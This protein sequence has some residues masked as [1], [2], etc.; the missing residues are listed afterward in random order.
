[1]KRKV[2]VLLRRGPRTGTHLIDDVVE[3]IYPD[4]IDRPWKKAH[5][6]PVG[7]YMS[8]NTAEASLRIYEHEA[9]RVIGYPARLTNYE[10]RLTT[11]QSRLGL[12]MA[13]VELGLIPPSDERDWE[14]WWRT[15]EPDWSEETFHAMWDLCDRVTFHEIIELPLQD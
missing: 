13:I 3:H 14:K 9:R 6:V 15:H 1:M 5:T 12:R 7:V 11:R 4:G 8:R 2:F 10:F